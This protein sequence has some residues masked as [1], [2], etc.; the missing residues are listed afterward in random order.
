[1]ELIKDVKNGELLKELNE[2]ENNAG[3]GIRNT[4]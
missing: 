2:L 3:K 1:M 4:T